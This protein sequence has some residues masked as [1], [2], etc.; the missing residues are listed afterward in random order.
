MA[1][2]DKLSDLERKIDDFLV[3]SEKAEE[4]EAPGTRDKISAD[5]ENKPDK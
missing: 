2:E 5:Q 1:L 4:H 3:A